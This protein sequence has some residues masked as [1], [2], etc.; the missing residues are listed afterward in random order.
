MHDAVVL[1]DVARGVD[2]P[3]AGLA[4]ARR[5]RTPPRSPSSSPAA[6]ASVTSG[7]TPAP[8]TT[9]SRIDLEPAL[10]DDLAHPPVAALEA[11]QLVAAV[12][13]H[14]V[15]LEQPA[16]RSRPACA[17]KTAR[18][19]DLLH[20]SRSCSACRAASAT[21]PPPADVGAA[22]QHHALGLLGV[23]A[24][25]V[26]VAQRAQVVDPLQLA[27][28]DA[29]AA[30]R[31][32][33]S[34]AAPCRTPPPRSWT[35]SPSRAPGPASSRSCASSARCAARPTTRPGG[36]RSPRATPCP[37]GTP[38]SRAAGC[39]ADPARGRRAGSPSA[40]RLAQP[41]RAVRGRQ[42]AADQQEL[43][44]AIRHPAA[45]RSPRTWA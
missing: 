15:L 42:A 22:D 28:V 34:P 35:A 6:R 12:H 1:G 13:L 10:R 33:P 40:A 7:V 24:D 18:A 4:A 25:R 37:A 26:G 17:P 21:P 39:R 45:S 20:A 14:P 30:A 41:A 31:S 16:G 38:S 11:R 43:D 44:V 3:G 19:R 5:T 2:R 8:I 27:P 36:S 32:R 23:L 29:A 9:T